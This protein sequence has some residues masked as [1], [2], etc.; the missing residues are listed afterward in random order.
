MIQIVLELE[1]GVILGD[2]FNRAFKV[3]K[4]ILQLVPP[5]RLVDQRCVWCEVRVQVHGYLIERSLYLIH[6]IQLCVM[7]VQ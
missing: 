1:N 3:G 7:D 2:S 6:Q 4:F 5:D